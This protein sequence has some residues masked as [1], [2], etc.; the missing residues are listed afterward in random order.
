MGLSGMYLLGFPMH[1]VPVDAINLYGMG[2]RKNALPFVNWHMN[3]D[4]FFTNNRP[5]MYTDVLE[6]Q[7]GAFC[8]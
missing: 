2:D 4:F 8:F 7:I 5:G 3:I 6:P 1:M